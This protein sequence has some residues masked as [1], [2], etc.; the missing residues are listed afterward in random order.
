MRAT[1]SFLLWLGRRLRRAL[2]PAPSGPSQRF[3]D[4]A[5]DQP[6]PP[7]GGPPAQ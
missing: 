6:R 7:L 5:L 1:V 2:A 3:V 4:L